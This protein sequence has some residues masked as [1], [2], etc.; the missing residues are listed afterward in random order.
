M[1]RALL[2]ELD[3]G[4]SVVAFPV[5]RRQTWVCSRDLTLFSRLETANVESWLSSVESEQ[6]TER[7]NQNA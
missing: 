3:G 7:G 2:S 6:R 1:V 5:S 4:V